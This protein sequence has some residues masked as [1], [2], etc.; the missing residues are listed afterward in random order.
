M[1]SPLV[2][3]RSPFPDFLKPQTFVYFIGAYT[4][5]LFV[6]RYYQQVLAWFKRYQIAVFS[7]VV[8]SSILV[9]LSYFTDYPEFGW[10]SMRQSLIYVQKLL[11]A[12]LVMQWLDSVCD[13]KYESRFRYINERKSNKLRN[14]V[15]RFLSRLGDMAFSVYF[16]HVYCM[17]WIIY[18]AQTWVIATRSAVEIGLLG[19]ASL[20]GSIL[21]SMLL[22][23]IIQKITGKYSRKL[24]GA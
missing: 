13:V 17:G 12:G 9:C 10:F 18:A 11:F 6:G 7:G 23:W 22:T 2:I 24:I 19:L 14:Y 1:L 8:I 21:M 20:I 4:V 3:S 16:I 5:G 15:F